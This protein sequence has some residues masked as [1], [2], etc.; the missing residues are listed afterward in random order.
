MERFIHRQNLELYRKLLAESNAAELKDGERHRVLLKLLVDEET[1]DQQPY[2]DF[3]YSFRS[4]R[5][6]PDRPS[7]TRFSGRDG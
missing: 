1:K 6:G 4:V 7:A 3:P 2:T 5:P